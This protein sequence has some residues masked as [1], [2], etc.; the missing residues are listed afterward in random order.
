MKSA[1]VCPVCASSRVGAFMTATDNGHLRRRDITLPVDRCRS[2]DVFFLNPPPPAE[3]GREYFAE[4]YSAQNGGN[5]YYDDAFKARVSDVRLDLINKYRQGVGTLVDVGCG[6][7]QFVHA[8]RQRGWDAWGVELDAGACAYANRQFG[9]NTVLNGS[10]DHAALPDEV[11]VVT[12][13]DVIE[14]VPDPVAVLRAAAG[15]LATDGLIV[16]RTANIRSWSFD[17]HRE[18]WWAFGSDHRFYFS[19]RSLTV[20]LSA[21]GFRV[22]DVL[23]CEISERPDKHRSRDIS[24]TSVRD[25]VKALTRS[26]LKLRKA[27]LYGKNL[28]RRLSGEARYGAHYRTSIVTVVAVRDLQRA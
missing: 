18:R 16:V 4:A 8:A 17:R 23:N 12:L 14:H 10:L 6:K 11:D 1:Q 20:A 9:L 13:W 15:R 26:P 27:G 22:L 19:P 21:A 3:I 7:A 5:V 24:E 25:G 28:L 2:C